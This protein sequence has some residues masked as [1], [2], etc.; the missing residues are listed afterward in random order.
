VTLTPQ[1][2]RSWKAEERALAAILGGER[3]P[4]SGRTRGW[5]P[6]V[7]HPIYAIEVKSRKSQLVLIQEMMDQA[8]KAS[9]WSVRRDEGARVP[10]GIYHVQGTH[11]DSS[12][13]FMRLK[14][15]ME[16]T[17]HS[18]VERARQLAAEHGWR[19]K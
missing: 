1:R 12:L 8:V 14:D 5:A 13:V 19:S 11:Y 7:K 15:F 6:D 2:R 10:L 3:V 16:I 4:V 18:A 17:G 9:A